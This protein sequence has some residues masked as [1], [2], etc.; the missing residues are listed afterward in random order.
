MNDLTGIQI[1]QYRI[2]E[3]SGGGG[4]GIVYK[5]KD[6]KLERI[7]ALKFLPPHLLTDDE[8]EKR[9]MS[10]A[11]S[12]SSLD[13]PNI[14]T[15]YD[16]NKT[17]DGQLFI[18]MAFY[19]GE[20]LKKIIN[21]GALNTDEAV[22]IA[23]QIASGLERAHKSGIVHRDVKPANIMITKFGEVKIVDFGLAKS[24]MSGGVTKFGSTIGT[25]AY[26]SPEQTRGENVDQRTDI[27]AL[28][29]ILYEMISGTS[30]FKG[31]YEQAIIYSILND[32]LPELK[33]IPE[34]LKSVIRKSTAKNPYDRYQNIS[35]M[36]SD[37]LIIK[38][39]SGSRSSHPRI[40][41][42]KSRV[43]KNKKWIW[44]S[45]ALL[46]LL[47]V[48]GWFYFNR[49]STEQTDIS[50]SKKMIV[51]LPFQNLGSS[52]D[53]YFADGI[54]GEI[55]SKLSGL[56]GL[57]VIARASAMQYKNTRK[58]LREIG[59]ELGVQYVL[60]GTVQWEKLNGKKRIR[61]NPE[62][63]SLDNATQIWSK[64]Y[65]ADF[66][67]AFTLQSEIAS[68]VA[69]AMNL[70]LVKSEQKSLES[71][72]TS[73]S[74]AYDLYLKARYFAEDITNEKNS[75]IA[76]ELL[77]QAI[78]IDENFAE[79]YAQ[80]SVVRS[81]MFWSY[82]ERTKD[83]LDKAKLSAE[84][85]LQL[86]PDLP[87]AH[88]AMGDY[89]YHGI[90]DYNSALEQYNEALRISPN[91]INALNGTAYVLRR[92]G[93]MEETINYL[94]KTYAINPKDYMIVFSL[95]ETYGLLR[96]YIDAYPYIDKAI[97]LAPE[98]VAAY[99][100]KANN[101][102]LENGNTKKAREI[103]RSAQGKKV[104]LDSDLFSNTLFLCDILDRNYPGALKDINGI[105]ETD[106][107]FYYKPEDLYIAQA[108]GFMKNKT[109]ADQH[110]KAAIKVIQEKIK[111]HPEDSRLYSS[112]GICY[113]GLGDKQNAIKEGKHGYEL[114]PVTKEAWR[115]TFRLYDLAQIYTM[116]GE[117]DLALEKIEELL[118]MPTDAISVAVLKL[119]PMWDS[120]H[121]NKRYLELIENK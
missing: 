12:A 22:N 116:V 47:L 77:Q 51:V 118:N 45:A 101:I 91:N 16:I 18:A 104:G 108:Y 74:E 98:A 11:K 50:N 111:Q 67:S 119:D 13:H 113:A 72:I 112:L 95:G 55:T 114:L 81:N 88:A 3:K 26:M 23:L 4:M 7:V 17:D 8:A 34:E 75:R 14:C 86:N 46:I 52:D 96:K 84:K 43:G 54:T 6:E 9:F 31:E 42:N 89:F 59:K 53:E 60:E 61:V 73:N 36:C 63:I 107:Q 41:V 71:N 94:K 120:L 62:L 82:F 65:E 109:E 27:W 97:Y 58:S 105:K 5:A 115:G 103:I 90:L 44:A 38:G 33:E 28:G 110:Y 69:E 57:G 25:A 80:L 83:N 15:I 76:L 66:S 24:K 70:K 121:N 35:E 29:I 85:A 32:E 102:L 1:L 78:E 68:T 79:A 37:L 21:R 10:E 93:K 99:D 106:G 30:A 49:T 100:L 56:S 40:V 19:E 2:L 48:S 117:Y 92:Q 20:T 64:P 87:D 39:D